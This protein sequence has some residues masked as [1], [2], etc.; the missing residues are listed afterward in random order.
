MNGQH[1][2]AA[3]ASLMFLASPSLAQQKDLSEQV[4]DGIEK[5]SHPRFAVR[6]RASRE[7]IGMGEPALKSLKAAMASKDE[8]V[9]RR[10]DSII[11]VIEARL[12]NDALL[13]AP[14]LRLQYESKPLDEAIADLKQKTGLPFVLDPKSGKNPKQP[15]ALDTGDVPYWEAIEK[16]LA[17]AGLVEMADAKADPGNPPT[18][19]FNGRT[20]VYRQ[21]VPAVPEKKFHLIENSNPIEASTS[22]LIRVKVLPKAGP[23]TAMTKAPNEIQFMLDVTPAPSL[24]WQG[25]VNVDV[26]KAIDERGTILAQSHLTN[27]SG[28]NVAV[29]DGGQV[30]I[31]GQQPIIVQG[32]LAQIFADSDWGGPEAVA[33]NPRHIPVTLIRNNAGSKSLK[34]LE[35]IVTARVLAPAQP[36][37]TV[38]SLL[39]ASLK[40]SIRQGDY[41]IEITER[42][43][44]RAGAVQVRFRLETPYQTEVNFQMPGRRGA[45]Q[46]ESVSV[47]NS[48]TT[49][50]FQDGEGKP[51]T[52]V[53]TNLLEQNSDEQKQTSDYVVVLPKTIKTTDMVKLVLTGRRSVCVEVPFVL[54]NVPL[55]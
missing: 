30:I 19:L 12:L 21:G 47:V 54:K 31:G 32:Q 3:L 37:L 20:R 18:P 48:Q 16:F 49:V 38:E 7:L 9:R 40:Q 41:R 24:S 53:A 29:P 50:G 6:D 23:D 55:P 52:N 8:E 5:L 36:L 26:R 13:K 39:T 2:L 15:I 17:I 51:L 10:A 25:L 1:T 33:R 45:V 4:A 27:G 42:T 35:G 14:T 22:T 44:T 34:H 28:G 43:T 46:I 11:H